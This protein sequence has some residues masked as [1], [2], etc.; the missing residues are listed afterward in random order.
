[1]KKMIVLSGSEE[2]I[3]G[4]DL[5]EFLAYAEKNKLLPV[6]ESHYRPQLVLETPSLFIEM[7]KDKFGDCVYVM[8]DPC[9]ILANAYTDG[10]L[11]DLIEENNLTFIHTGA[12]ATL[13]EIFDSMDQEMKCFLKE[14]VTEAWEEL[15]NDAK[16]EQ[17]RHVAVFYKESNAKEV[18][19]FVEGL[20]H[21]ENMSVCVICLPE[22]E[23]CIK[24]VVQDVLKDNYISEAI[25]YDK[26]MASPE[27]IECLEELSLEYR[28]REQD[29]EIRVSGMKLS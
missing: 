16:F 9:L 24:E 10:K 2:N 15:K 19:A 22:Y 26:E 7:L 4:K 17:I 14:I 8:N 23:E 21:G 5:F 18:D 13:K 3:K 29:F 6:G 12:D 20:S 1:M 11:V 27:F 28:Y 25:I